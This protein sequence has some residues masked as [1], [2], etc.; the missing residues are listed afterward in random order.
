MPDV[1]AEATRRRAAA[2]TM[3][4]FGNAIERIVAGRL[5]KQIADRLD[6]QERTIKAHMS[7]IFEKLGARN[8][9]HAGVIL[10]GLDIT[11]PAQRVTG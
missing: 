10:R 1:A 2:V 3:A 11:D 6:V 5:N 4:D 8:R 7:A 9:T